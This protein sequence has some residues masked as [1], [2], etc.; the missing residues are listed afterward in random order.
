M[1]GVA[2]TDVCEYG[3][4]VLLSRHEAIRALKRKHTPCCHGFRVW[5]SSWLLIDY[6]DYM[7]LPSGV[8]VLEVGC[9]WGAAGIYLA[10]M[11]DA[12]VTGVDMDSEVFPFLQLHADL[13]DVRISVLEQSFEAL[14]SQQLAEFDL[15]I[16]SDICFWPGMVNP[17]GSLILRALDAGVQMA[18]IADPGRSSFEELAT[19]FHRRGMGEKV[20]WESLRPYEINGRILKIGGMNP[21][22]RVYEKAV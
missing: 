22:H 10:K 19:E 13:N 18:L 7:G 12:R 3:L 9:G 1:S 20:R 6:C 17:L 14:T 5:P 11:H 8:R 2:K 15:I 16:G 21:G 4:H